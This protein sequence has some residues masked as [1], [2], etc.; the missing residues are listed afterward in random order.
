MLEYVLSLGELKVRPPPT[1]KQADG[2][3]GKSSSKGSAILLP[4]L[5]HLNSSEAIKT[6]S[7]TILAAY[8]N[9]EL[10]EAPLLTLLLNKVRSWPNVALVGATEGDGFTDF[11]DRARLPIVTFVHNSLDSEA[12]V[13]NIYARHGIICRAGFFLSDR[14]LLEWGAANPSRLNENFAVTG[15]VRI[16]FA[17][18]NSIEEVVHLVKCLEGLE[19]W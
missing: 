1:A 14:S 8:Q 15:A 10:A 12:L 5:D 17:H 19:G 7:R 6:N 9:I 2:T 3:G 11:S 4:S 16:S 13:D 18:Y